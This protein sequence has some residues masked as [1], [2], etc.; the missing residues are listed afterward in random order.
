MHPVATAARTGPRAWWFDAPGARLE[1]LQEPPAQGALRRVHFDAQP[2]AKPR[3]NLL[4]QFRSQRGRDARF[5]PPKVEVRYG[6]PLFTHSIFSVAFARQAAVP[7][8]AKVLYR[9]GKGGIITN[10]RKRNND[11]LIFFGEFYVIL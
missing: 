8:I 2:I 3:D 4:H 10:T 1:N 5:P 11:T 6:T 7:S 9:G